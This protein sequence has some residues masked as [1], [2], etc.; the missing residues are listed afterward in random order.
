M[1]KSSK[2]ARGKVA[3]GNWAAQ[4]TDGGRMHHSMAGVKK[5]RGLANLWGAGALYKCMTFVKS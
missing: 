5:F 3:K 4:V 1:L 2:K